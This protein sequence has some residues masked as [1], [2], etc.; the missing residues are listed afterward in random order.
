[1]AMAYKNPPTAVDLIIEV[2]NWKSEFEGIVLI[3]R[4]NYPLGHAFPGGFQEEGESC[5][6]AAVREAREETGLEVT[7][8]EQ[9]KFY[10]E[11]H[12]DPRKHINSIG[13][14]ARAY[15]KP[16]GGDD[17]V[18]AK[19]YALDK[20]PKPLAFDHEKRFEEYLAWRKK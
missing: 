2:Y 19:V 7:L 8:I 9:L 3:E 10:S 11:P 12:R 5:E 18:D 15:G 16:V 14:V 17:A 13:Y 4:K 20:I 6:T 1:M